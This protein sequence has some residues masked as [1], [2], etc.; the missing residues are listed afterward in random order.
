MGL[1][2]PAL[3]SMYGRIPGF[4]WLLLETKV[5]ELQ[6]V[7]GGG[8]WI[9][10]LEST[11]SICQFLPLNQYIQK[12]NLAFHGFGPRSGS[13]PAP[14]VQCPS[15]PYHDQLHPI[16][17]NYTFN[18]TFNCRSYFSQWRFLLYQLLIKS[19][20]YKYPSRWLTGTILVQVGSASDGY[21]QSD[22]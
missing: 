21:D 15:I 4:G 2:A 9:K 1:P 22:F 7:V 12:T 6:F 10:V 16:T 5:E 19:A 11:W 18:Y 14:A 20:Q 13:H 3:L 8:L 17:S